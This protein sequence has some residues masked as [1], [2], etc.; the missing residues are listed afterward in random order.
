MM[1]LKSV[2]HWDQVQQFTRLVSTGANEFVSALEL[3]TF[4]NL[5]V[6]VYSLANIHPKHQSQLKTI[7]CGRS[8][9]YQS[10]WFYEYPS[11]IYQ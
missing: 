1:K 5:A 4:L 3:L 2:I 10:V 11:A 6:F 8:C 7:C 9:K